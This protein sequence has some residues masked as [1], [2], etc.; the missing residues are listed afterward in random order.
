MNR[1][2]IA[3]P[4]GDP[5]GIGPEI[6]S[7]ALAS[8]ELYSVCRPLVIGDGSVMRQAMKFCGLSLDINIA[9][10]AGEGIYKPG[11]LDLVDM[12][13]VD[14]KTLRIGEVQAQGGKAAFEYI[15]KAV[16]MALAKDVDAIATTPINK[17]SL[18]AANV[19]YIGHTEILAGL[20]GARDPLTMF[21]VRNMRVFFLTRHVSLRKACELVTRERL[22]DYIKRCTEA[23]RRLGITEGAMA[24][25]GLNPHSGEHGLFGDEEMVH[26]IPA[27]EEAKRLGYNVEGPIGADSVF[28]LALQGRF[29]SVLSLYHDQGHIATKTLDFERTIALTV[30]LPFLRTSVD[31]GTAFDIAGTGKASAVS[32]IEAIRL[33]AKYSPMYNRDVNRQN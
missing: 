5:A 7:K 6:V 15:R 28:H 3:I 25:A 31:H 23:L 11:T 4:M 9:G 26:I 24:I 13:N 10:N 8:D 1:P 12:E 32:M 16:D 33:A 21:E 19:D 2:I 18:K 29:N 20:T 30:G 22:L 14:I 27:V 17:E